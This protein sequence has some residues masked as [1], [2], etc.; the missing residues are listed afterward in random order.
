MKEI[1]FT[2]STVDE[3]VFY[4]GRTRYTDESI[5]TGPDQEEIYQIIEDLKRFKLI[6][7]AEEYIQNF[8]WVNI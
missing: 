3:F 5:I 1:G 7:T 8:L 6:L 2:H 4:R